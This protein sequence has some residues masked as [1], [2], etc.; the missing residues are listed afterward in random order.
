[1][2]VRN[3]SAATRFFSDVLMRQR[4][5]LVLIIVQMGAWERM[6]P[7]S[8]RRIASQVSTQ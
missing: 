3:S 7:D 2:R 8:L 6:G 1:M 4:E 5:L